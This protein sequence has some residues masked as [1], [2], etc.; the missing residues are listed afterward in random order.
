MRMVKLLVFKHHRHGVRVS[1]HLRFKQL[2]DR[3]MRG[4]PT[5]CYSTPPVTDAFLPPLTV[6]IPKGA[7]TG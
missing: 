4:N 2:M 6:A 1:C 5:G 3:G 7:E